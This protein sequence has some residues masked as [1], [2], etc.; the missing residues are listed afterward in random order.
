MVYMNEIVDDT[1]ATTQG[2]VE[3]VLHAIVGPTLEKCRNF[4]P[5]VAELAVVLKEDLVLLFGPFAAVVELWC[6]MV[7]PPT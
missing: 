6:Q 4:G 2:R 5:F 1:H 7:V 3:V